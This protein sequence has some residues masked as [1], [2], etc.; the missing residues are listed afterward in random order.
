MLQLVLCL[1]LQ[2]YSKDGTRVLHFSLALAISMFQHLI[3][4]KLMFI[5]SQQIRY[6]WFIPGIRGMIVL[7]ALD[8]FIQTLSMQ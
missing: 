7:V 1:T 8:F 6:N 3:L 5:I 2:V 4:D